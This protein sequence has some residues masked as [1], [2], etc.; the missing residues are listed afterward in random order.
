MLDFILH[1]ANGVDTV[2]LNRQ[3]PTFRAVTAL[4][5]EAEWQVEDKIVLTIS[6][7]EALTFGIGD[8]I[9]YNG[10][11]YQVFTNYSSYRAVTENKRTYKIAF[12]DPSRWLKKANLYNTSEIID[13]TQPGGY[14]WER[15]DNELV[16]NGDI[17]FL[18]NQLCYNLNASQGRRI[19]KLGNYP[20]ELVGVYKDFTFSDPN[21]LVCSHEIC[22]ELGTFYTVRKNLDGDTDY[23]IDFGEEPGYF[24]ITLRYGKK[25]GLYRLELNNADEEV[26]TQFVVQGSSENLP[27]TYPKYRLSLDDLYPDSMI[28]CPE[29]YARWGKSVKALNYDDIKPERTG[30]VS[31]LVEGDINSFIDDTL[32]F[33]PKGGTIKFLSGPMIGHTLDCVEYNA[34]T[35][36]V[37]L[38]PYEDSNHF[39]IPSPDSEAYRITLGSKYNIDGI[40][41][42]QSYVTDAQS[43]MLVQAEKDVE[44]LTQ[45]RASYDTRVERDLI[46]EEGV[47]PEV[48]MFLR[49]VHPELD[50]DKFLRVKRI[51]QNILGVKPIYESFEVS[52]LDNQKADVE[53]YKK[54]VQAHIIAKKKQQKG[55]PGETPIRV[56]KFTTPGYEF[57]RENAA[58]SATLSIHIFQ[59]EEDITGT[60]NIARFVWSRV[61]ENDAGDTIWNELHANSGSSVDITNADLVGD[62]SFIVQFWDEYKTEILQTTNF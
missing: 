28:L 46:E 2:E 50:L 20:D 17:V 14:R 9:E 54:A 60:I 18:G 19:F 41:L 59:G 38:K 51:S 52:D 4:T 21:C 25:Q 56:E 61:S 8:W 3:H 40:G 48:G 1:K 45:P 6:S 15:V 53:M 36:K 29:K 27:S 44:K 24:P 57:Y 31:A 39:I 30:E 33:S 23:I 32:T 11:P 43:R 10:K 62:T 13:D 34:T 26:Y 22:E 55:D 58:Y 37:T 35:H 16:S 12:Y 7:A 47:V 42:P 49:I 5:R